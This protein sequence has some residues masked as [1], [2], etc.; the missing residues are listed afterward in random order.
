MATFIKFQMVEPYDDPI[1]VNIDWIRAVTPDI[2][3]EP[4]LT[5]LHLIDYKDEICDRTGPVEEVDTIAVEGTFAE[6]CQKIQEALGG[7]VI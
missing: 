5:S 7:S 4:T 3:G 1:L 6:I 2:H